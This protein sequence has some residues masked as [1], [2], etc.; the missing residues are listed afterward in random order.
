MSGSAHPLG[1][2][3]RSRRVVSSG[4][5]AG[6]SSDPRHHLVFLFPARRRGVWRRPLP[7]ADYTN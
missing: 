6:A 1:D 2:R 4:Q 5:A 3:A 7:P